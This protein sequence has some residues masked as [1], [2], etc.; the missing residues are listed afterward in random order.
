MASS[1]MI[2]NCL[3]ACSSAKIKEVDPVCLSPFDFLEE[4]TPVK[5]CVSIVECPISTYL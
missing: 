5:F 1:V 3:A 2:G 4:V